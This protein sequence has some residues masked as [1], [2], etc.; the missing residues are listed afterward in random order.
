MLVHGAW[1]HGSCWDEVSALLIR[2]GYPVTAVTAAAIPLTALADDVARVQSILAQQTGPTILVG[3]S[4]GGAVISGAGYNQPNVRALVYVSAFAPDQGESIGQL[5]GGSGFPP[6]PGTAIGPSLFL[7]TQGYAYLHRD[8]Y[9]QYFAPDVS[10]TVA[11]IK[12]AAQRPVESP[13]GQ[14]RRTRGMEDGA[15]VV[16]C[17][18]ERSDD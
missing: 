17:I 14:H 3:H 11:R 5:A 13:N 4:I 6:E 1:A 15:V 12:A 7:D 18:N 16:P 8:A 9:L 2:V 10:P